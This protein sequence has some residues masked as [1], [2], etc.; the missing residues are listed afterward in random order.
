MTRRSRVM[1]EGVLTLRASAESSSLEMEDA[2]VT[3]LDD[4]LA[5]S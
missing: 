3:P 5:M 1:A 4:W 2:G